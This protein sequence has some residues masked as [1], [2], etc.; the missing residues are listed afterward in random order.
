MSN[1]LIHGTRSKHRDRHLTVQAILDTGV[2][3][4][5]GAQDVVAASQ[6]ERIS[7]RVDRTCN[8]PFDSELFLVNFQLSDKITHTGIE[9]V[10]GI[11][12]GGQ[13]LLGMD[14]IL[15]GNLCVANDDQGIHLKYVMPS[16]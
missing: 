16:N 3:D 12:V 7:R 15:K 5:M 9:V 10:R 6:L 4:S 13:I 14:V 2:T 11:V 8:E 1:V